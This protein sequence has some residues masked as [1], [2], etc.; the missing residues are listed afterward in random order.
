M[1]QRAWSGQLP[2]EISAQGIRYAALEADEDAMQALAL[3][4]KRL[5]ERVEDI[6]RRLRDVERAN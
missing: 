5:R 4:T 6:E 3:D 2:V 1:I